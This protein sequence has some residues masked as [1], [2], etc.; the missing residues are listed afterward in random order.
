MGIIY[1]KKYKSR[2]ICPQ[3]ISHQRTVKVLTHQSIQILKSLGLKVIPGG[4]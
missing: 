2:E 1:N 4:R 3:S